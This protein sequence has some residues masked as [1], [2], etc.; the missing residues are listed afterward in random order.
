MPAQRIRGEVAMLG[1]GPMS[2]REI[3]ALAKRFDVSAQAML[4]RLDSLRLL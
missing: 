1:S 2:D 3:E 4:N